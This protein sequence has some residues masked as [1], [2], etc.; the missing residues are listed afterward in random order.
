V[1][2]KANPDL[3]ERRKLIFIKTTQEIQQLPVRL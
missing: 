2:L 1:V 3:L